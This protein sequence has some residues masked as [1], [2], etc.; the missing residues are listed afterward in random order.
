MVIYLDL[1]NT[2]SIKKK[3]GYLD[4]VFNEFDIL[5][6]LYRSVHIYIYIH[7]F[8]CINIYI[9]RDIYIYIDIYIDRVFL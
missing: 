8:I 9:Y 5:M 1:Q 2:M 6:Y 7:I 3:H 4:V